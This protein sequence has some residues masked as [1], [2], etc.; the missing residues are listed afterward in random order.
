[1]FDLRALASVAHAVGIDR[2]ETHAICAA[3]NSGA[4]TV[5]ADVRDV[6]V[7]AAAAVF[8]D[9]SR[10]DDTARGGSEPPLAWCMSLPASRVAVKT[11]PGVDL[12]A[13]GT[14]WEVEFVAEGRD[15]KEACLWSP[16]WA[17]VARRA[18]VLPTGESLVGSGNGRA[19]VRPP[20][21][22]VLDPSPA[23]TRAG[24]VAEL[25]ATVRGWQADPKIA[26]LYADSTTA[27]AFGR[28][29]RVEASMP[30]ALKPLAA[31]LRR[32]DV[33]SLDLRR[34]G[35]AGDVAELGRRLRPKQSPGST[36]SRRATVL[37]TR[38][39][40]RPWAFICFELDAD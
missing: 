15:L 6:R 20:G 4:A 8:V 36:Q 24:L 29:L 21:A 12:R 17:T 38:V 23:V 5:V 25:A 10:R 3:N 19:E 9:P 11:A 16:G 26:F 14:G 32:L 31:E 39:V 30:F 35:L 28:W 34:R 37:L 13:V 40:N 27:T 7:D 18:T 2:D 22:F 1:G 33:G